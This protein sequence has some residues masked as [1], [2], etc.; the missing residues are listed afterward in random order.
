MR[1]HGRAIAVLAQDTEWEGR[2]SKELQRLGERE[3]EGGRERE[4]ERER[5]RGE[6]SVL[7]LM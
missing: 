1:A 7:G 3:G 4:R 6:M 5:E 2:E